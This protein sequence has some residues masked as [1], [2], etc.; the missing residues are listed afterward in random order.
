[1]V[2]KK[3]EFGERDKE[4][5]FQHMV[6]KGSY[7]YSSKAEIESLE[8]ELDWHLSDIKDAKRELRKKKYKNPETLD[9]WDLSEY[10]RMKEEIKNNKESI[11]KCRL[12]INESRK[13]NEIIESEFPGN[14]S[15]FANIKH[16]GK[17]S[18]AGY[19]LIDVKA[20]VEADTVYCFTRQVFSVSD[21]YSSHNVEQIDGRVYLLLNRE[22][23]S[24]KYS[25]NY[26][27]EE[28]G[29]MLKE[30]L[31]KK[32]RR[33]QQLKKQIAYYENRSADQENQGSRLIP[34]EVRFEVW[35]RD[36]GKC[37]QC[38]SKENL[39]FDHIIPFS[40]GGANTARNL[41]L[42]CQTCNR[43]KSDTI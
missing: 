2:F 25:P 6:E 29:L 20:N 31:Y 3:E 35:R 9:G 8:S 21:D 5:I 22:M 34:E 15:E 41:Q 32:D 42:L 7:D 19:I 28:Y 37:V 24:A 18:N 4:R 1:M 11:K 26:T 39:E 23:Y 17:G 13:K 36:G 16:V 14:L 27:L 10:E 33:F 40:K 43:S 30:F 12:W 38:G